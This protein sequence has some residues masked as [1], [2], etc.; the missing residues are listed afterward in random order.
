MSSM[1][2]LTFYNLFFLLSVIIVIYGV[3]WYFKKPVSIIFKAPNSLVKTQKNVLLIEHTS[4]ETTYQECLDWLSIF[5]SEIVV[6]KFP[7]YIKAIHRVD[8]NIVRS[9][10]GSKSLSDIPKIIEFQIKKYAENDVELMNCVTINM[11]QREINR[12]DFIDLDWYK[13]EILSIFKDYNAHLIL[14]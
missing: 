6:Q 2:L 3:Y 8:L 11:D 5:N 14:R 9:N 1:E 4:P 10:G 13:Q 12:F 7:N